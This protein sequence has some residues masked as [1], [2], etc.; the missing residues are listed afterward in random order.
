M[1]VSDEISEKLPSAIEHLERSLAV[2]GTRATLVMLDRLFT[3]AQTFGLLRGNSAAEL[4]DR[5]AK[6]TEF[7]RSALDGLPPD[8]IDLAVQRTIDQGHRWQTL[9]LPAELR[10]IVADDYARRQLTLNRLKTAAL[11]RKQG[12]TDPDRRG[13]RQFSPEVQRMMDEWREK[14]GFPN[15]APG[16]GKIEEERP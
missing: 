15:T 13:D 1:P 14:R 16:R 4:K 11:R 3:W 5:I 8:L 12:T 2:A 6:A 7:Y 10:A 9:P